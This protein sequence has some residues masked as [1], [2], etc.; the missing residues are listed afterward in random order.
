MESEYKG[1]LCLKVLS[2]T[3]YSD[4]IIISRRE[5]ILRTR[6]L[7]MR[8]SWLFPK[9]IPLLETVAINGPTLIT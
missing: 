8:L 4:A 6:I 3:E 1:R 9:R 5:A 7:E 2:S